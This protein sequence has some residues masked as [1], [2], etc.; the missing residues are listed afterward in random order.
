MLVFLALWGAAGCTAPKSDPNRIDLTLWTINLSP[1]YNDYVHGLIKSFESSHPRIKV[2]WVD[3]PQAVSRQKL[4]AGIAAGQPPDVVNTSTDFA[5]TL[6]QNGAIADMDEYVGDQTRELYFQNIWNAVKVEGKVYAIPW[7]VTTKVLIY[8]KA[9]L[10]EAGLDPAKPPGTVEELDAMATRVARQTQAKGM[11]PTIRIWEDWS[12]ADAPTLDFKTMRPLFTAPESV[13]VLER[14]HRLYSEKVMPPE[15]LTEGYQGALDRYKAGSLA[16]LE[17]GPQL[18][19]RIKADAPGIYD[20]TGIC[21][22]PLSKS[23]T[24]PASTMNFVVPRAC[25]HRA[26]AVELA[27]FLTRPE[28]QLEFCKLVPILP[29]TVSTASDSYFQ[30]DGPDKLQSQAVR[31]S[32]KQ[33]PRACDFNIALP[34]RKDLMRALK[35]A[36]EASIRGESTTADSL[37]RA[38]TEWNVLLAPFQHSVDTL[39]RQ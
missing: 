23:G 20:Q 18:L 8:N 35:D 15:T 38:A 32:L 30:T 28:A 4:M 13:A 3:L 12:M 39:P 19:M 7:Y 37:R 6:A 11:M 9:V 27:L 21:P 5:L 24:L 34:R 26:E 1:T 25:P 33:L 2:K 36:V 10:K 14:Y 17:A 29:S 16:F 31:I 22:L